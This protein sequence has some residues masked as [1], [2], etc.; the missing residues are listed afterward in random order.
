VDVAVFSTST[1]VERRR[2]AAVAFSIRIDTGPKPGDP[3]F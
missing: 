2:T 3:P 1:N